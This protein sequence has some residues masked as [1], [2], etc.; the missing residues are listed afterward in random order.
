MSA[1]LLT[2]CPYPVAID[3]HAS[4]ALSLVCLGD[5]QL[6][7][8]KLLGRAECGVAGPAPDVPADWSSG[9]RV[10]RL[11]SKNSA[12]CASKDRPSF[13]CQIVNKQM[14]DRSICL[15]R[16]QQRFLMRQPWITL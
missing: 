13:R 3:Q 12:L 15:A 4:D 11:L 8:A 6:G 9:W 14:V 1:L 10:P 2:T 16:G 5:A 7:D